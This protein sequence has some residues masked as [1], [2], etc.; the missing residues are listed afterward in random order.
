[1]TASDLLV[2]RELLDFMLFDWLDLEDEE[3]D[4]DTLLAM[5]DSARD[6]ALDAFVP[7]LRASDIEEPKIVDG[8]VRIIEPFKAALADYRNLGLFGTSFPQELGGLG[9]PYPAS[10][11][12]STIFASANLSILSYAMLTAGNAHLLCE[13]GSPEQVE[14][15]ARPQIEGRWFGTM[16][17]SEPQAGSSLSDIQARARHEG[18]DA[19]GARYRISGNKMWISGG[20]QDASENL[21]HLVLAKVVAEDGGIVEGTKGISLFIVPK[22]LPDGS[23]N[24]VTVAGLNHKMGYRGTSNCLLNFGE[25][26]GA[27]GWLVGSVGKGLA[28]M[29]MMM[30][31]AR[32]GVGMGAA[33]IAYRGYREAARYA[34]DRKQ[35]RL[36]QHPTREQVSILAHADVRRMLLQ[37]KAYAEGGIALCL[38]GAALYDRIDEESAVLLSLL[39]PII[40]SWPSEFGL[41]AND[42]AIQIHGGCGYTRDF[43]VEQLWRDNRL[44]AIHEGTTGIQ[45]LDLLG[46][47]LLFSNGQALRLLRSR[48]H[49]TA[50]A[51]SELPQLADIGWG[52]AD[53]WTKIAE[54]LDRL[55]ASAAEGALDN[56][57]MFLRAFG[58]GV[59][60]WLWLDQAVAAARTNAP[61][62]SA[63]TYAAQ[64]FIGEELPVAEGWLRVAAARPLAALVPD[65]V[66]V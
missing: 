36:A 17:L 34:Q 4:R 66:L 21:V 3:H 62:K 63:I 42:L 6:L 27:T 2:S 9:L 14:R 13:F 59:V 56:A 22:I 11:A 46:R 48:I 35:G 44:N 12:I 8:Q 55:R 47:K 54:T 40:K 5:I 49:A 24:D 65:D 30:N 51:A 7:S 37:Q 38:F 18:A 23:P 19:L 25:N 57:T 10:L 29:F 16:C 15:F 26:G 20:D 31:E 43:I 41:V 1:M 64:Y 33:G 28:Q 53:Y 58:H 45:A 32:I 50:S 61:Q 52:L 60:A 39:T